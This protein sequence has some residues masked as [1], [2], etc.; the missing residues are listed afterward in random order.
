MKKIKSIIKKIIL[1]LFWSGTDSVNFIF[2]K[3][4]YFEKRAKFF[5][6]I[7]YKN[8]NAYRF[9]FLPLLNLRITDKEIENIKK[10][11]DSFFKNFYSSLNEQ[12]QILL[13]RIM[14]E[15]K[16]D[17]EKNIERFFEIAENTKNADVKYWITQSVDKIVFW[18]TLTLPKDFFIR[19]KVLFKNICDTYL[20]KK[21]SKLINQNKEDKKTVCIVTYLMEST[22]RNSAQRVLLMFAENI[23]RT[24]FDV[25]ILCLDSLYDRKSSIANVCGYKKSYKQHEK[26]EEM[27][28]KTVSIYYCTKNGIKNKLQESLDT[29]YKI[30]PDVIL[31][32]ADEYSVTSFIYSQDFKTIY[33]PLR[34]R[35]TA[36]YCTHYI[37]SAPA[38]TAE[39]SKIYCNILNGVK[40]QEWCFPE[41]KMPCNVTYTRKQYDLP[42]KNQILITTGIIPIHD[43]DF[44]DILINLLKDNSDIS[45]IIVGLTELPIYLLNNAEELIL[46]KQIINWGYEKNLPALYKICDIFVNPNRTGGSGA[47]AIAAQQNLPI[48]ITDYPSDALRWIHAENTV[49][50]GYEGFEKEILRLINDKSYY[51]TQSKKFRTLVDD[52]CESE[53][54]WNDFNKLL[55]DVVN[56]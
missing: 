24:L 5:N 23:D 30:N 16:I 22:I 50:D 18:N 46:N 41:Y 44:M 37:A 27:F 17:D 56:E 9:I 42:D 12:A 4:D 36:Q 47:I 11:Q 2:T 31:D 20:L 15:L 43:T 48:V 38:Q 21:P 32:M 45:W 13:L 26:I 29:I 19:R 8:K 53:K 33:T 34:R 49:T 51:E 7:C 40:L 6:Y 1:N 52:V 55:V 28:K 25:T 39:Q 35:V 54:I 3:K 14:S 10:A